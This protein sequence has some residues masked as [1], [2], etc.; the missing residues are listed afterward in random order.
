MDGSTITGCQGLDGRREGLTTKLQH[1]A[2]PKGDKSI[3]NYAVM[4]T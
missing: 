3:L 2:I 1:E 4:D